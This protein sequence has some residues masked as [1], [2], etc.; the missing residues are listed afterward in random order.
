MASYLNTVT[1]ERRGLSIKWIISPK[2]VLCTF[3][4]KYVLSVRPDP[5]DNI[6][7]DVFGEFLMWGSQ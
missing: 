3:F 6:S 5:D 7:A 4:Y 2:Y 1:W